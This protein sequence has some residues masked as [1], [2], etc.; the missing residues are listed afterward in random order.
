MENSS[1]E[2]LS[3]S[4]VSSDDSNTQENQ[5]SNKTVALQESSASFKNAAT[6][7][8]ALTDPLREGVG[9]EP[10][11]MRFFGPRFMTIWVM[12]IAVTGIVMEFLFVGPLRNGNPFN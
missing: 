3:S 9:N 10:K 11:K 5:V 6:P 2:S 7:Y 8:T 1:V 4:D 12:P